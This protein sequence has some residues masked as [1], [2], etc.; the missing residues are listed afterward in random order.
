MTKA[1]GAMTAA[2]VFLAGGIAL[3]QD[4][5]GQ[6][7]VTLEEAPAWRAVG[8]LN[9]AGNRYCTATLI[10]PDLVITAAHCI[11]HPLTRHKAHPE[12]IVFLAGFR[13]GD[14][15]ALRRAAAVAVLPDTVRAGVSIMSIPATTL[16][17]CGS[18]RP[19]P[20][21]RPN[22]SRLRP[23]TEPTRSA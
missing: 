6:R 11:F 16:P 20:R 15:A 10:A 23:G 13:Q 7:M 18:I 4:R 12:E 19:L 21:P 2:A 22:R 17:F 14:Y 3:A 9:I 1:I 5:P 8:R